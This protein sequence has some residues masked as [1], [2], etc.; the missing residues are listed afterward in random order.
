MQ[1]PLTL[2]VDTE[3]GNLQ[4][5][6]DVKSGQLQALLEVTRA[7]SVN[8]PSESLFNLYESIAEGHLSVNLLALYIYDQT[9]RKAVCINSEEVCNK[10]D[11]PKILETYGDVGEM[12]DSDKALY[13]GIKYVIPVY[14]D[15]QPIALALTGELNEGD[16]VPER[17]SP[18]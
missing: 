12:N 18:D 1:T 5:L 14:H 17:E 7:I 2:L 15:D 11:I 9:W 13:P 8:M 4:H 3:H 10:I 6:L 16:N